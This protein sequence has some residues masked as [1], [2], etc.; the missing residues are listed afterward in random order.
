MRF[1]IIPKKLFLC[2]PNFQ[3]WS[4]Q[5][6]VIFQGKSFSVVFMSCYNFQKVSIVFHSSERTFYLLKN[7]V[8]VLIRCQNRFFEDLHYSDIAREQLKGC[9]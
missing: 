9:L 3:N 7:A 8:K 4:I 6:K 5:S 2:H 1:T